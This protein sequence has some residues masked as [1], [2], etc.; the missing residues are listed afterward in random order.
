MLGTKHRFVQSA[1]CPAQSVDPHFALAIRGLTHKCAISGLRKHDEREGPL[2]TTWPALREWWNLTS[3]TVLDCE[4]KD[5]V[6]S[7]N[8][9]PTLLEDQRKEREDIVVEEQEAFY[10]ATSF[11][12]IVAASLSVT[13]T[14]LG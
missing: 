5:G 10:H 8:S 7:T 2:L 9:K 3:N 1:D 14:L 12:V 4:A 11:D 13:G 6:E